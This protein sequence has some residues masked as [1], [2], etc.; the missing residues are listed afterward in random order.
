MKFIIKGIKLIMIIGV[1]FLSS[2]TASVFE[3][4]VE[5]ASINS[6]VNLSTMALM[7]SENY[8]EE[9]IEEEIEEEIIEE[10]V[11]VQVQTPVDTSPQVFPSTSVVNPDY[12]PISTYTAD[13]TGYIYNCPM[14]TGKLACMSSLDLSGGRT[15]Y[16]DS[17]YGEVSI[18]ASSSNLPCGSIVKFETS[19]LSDKPIYAVVLDRGVVGNSLD[20]LVKDYNYAISTVGRISITYDVLRTG[21]GS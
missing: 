2:S 3:S 1:V 12:V 6:T 9:I 19:R 20:I 10:E 15:T 14:C 13:L 4:S 5:N 18:V 17:E 8:V 16:E 7:I 11:Q 21:W